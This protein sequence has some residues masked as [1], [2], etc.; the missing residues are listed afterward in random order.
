MKNRYFT[1]VELLITAGIFAIFAA[2]LQ[3]ALNHERAKAMD[4]AC[5]N[6]LKQ[7][8]VS[9]FNYAHD[10]KDI[11][12]VSGGR[13]F[14]HWANFYGVKAPGYFKLDKYIVNGSQQ[15]WSNAVSC[16]AAV[17]PTRD[18]QMG[19]HTYG[20]I[21]FRA[22]G[23]N[24]KARRWQGEGYY[25]PSFGDPWL[26]GKTSGEAYLKLNLIKNASEFILYADSAWA[27]KSKK[28][29]GFGP[30]PGQDINAFYLHAD[31]SSSSFGVA[32]RHSSSANLVMSD[33]HVAARN[34]QKLKNGLMFVHSGVDGNGI[35]KKF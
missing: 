34:S 10:M 22:Y 33:G 6:N 30:Y 5:K 13:G 29:D 2:I 20:M 1:L 23:K 21:N 3:P 17:P 15:F 7:C 26:S 19:S 31:W 24:A 12:T 35:Y 27:A 25:S 32:L 11:V 8:S 28:A 9:A 18:A 16:P 4:T 14:F